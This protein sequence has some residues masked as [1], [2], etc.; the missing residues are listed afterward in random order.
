MGFGLD[1]RLS[2]DDITAWA[3]A[4][5]PD[6]GAAQRGRQGLAAQRRPRRP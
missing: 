5:R 6:V 4:K 3:A 1:G 2:L